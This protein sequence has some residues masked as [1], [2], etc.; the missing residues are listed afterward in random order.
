LL[1]KIVLLGREEKQFN[2]VLGALNDYGF[3]FEFINFEDLDKH[4]SQVIDAKL[5]ILDT[6]PFPES[7][8]SQFHTLRQNSQL[9]HIPVLALVKDSP[10]RLRY[11]IVNLGITEYLTVPF[12]RLDLQMRV[13]NIFQHTNGSMRQNNYESDSNQYAVYALQSLKSLYQEMDKSVVNLGKDTFFDE[14]LESLR[15]LSKAHCAML[16]DVAEEDHLVLTNV[17][18]GGLLETGCKLNILN[19]PILH[20]AV[21]LGEPT[22]LNMI[23][24]DNPF[25]MLMRSFFNI[26][27]KSC[28]V[29]PIQIQKS[30]RSILC[31]LKSDEEKLSEFHYLLVQNF[32]HFIVHSYQLKDLHNEV[33]E[34]L[35]NQIW[36]FYFDFLEQVVN[37]LSFGILV[38]GK[39]QRINYLNEHAAQLLSVLPKETLYRP[40]DEVLDK[41]VIE[42]IMKSKRNITLT[43][44]RP[45]FELEDKSGKKTLI[46]YS[47][48][49]FS[50]KINQEEGYIISLKDI[51]YTKEMQEEMRRVDRL[52]SLGVMASGIAHEIRNPLAG[53][54][55]MVQTF[56]EEL[57]EDDAKRE[58]MRRIVRLVNRLDKLIRTLFSYAKPSKPNR[59]TCNIESILGDV[60]SLLRQKIKE[61]NIKLSELV[62]PDLPDVFVDPSQIQQVLVNLILNSVEAIERDG[63]I[64]ISIQP[65]NSEETTE[66]AN[67]PPSLALGKSRE[68]IEIKI[69]DNG[70]GISTENIQHIFNPFFT[71]KSFGTGLGLS[72]V[73]QIIKDNDGLINYESREGN[74]TTC[75]LYLPSEIEN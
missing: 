60:I 58:Y 32:A 37:Q 72:I 17:R 70:C 16:F 3:Q 31:L 10:P 6:I 12:D 13:R 62:H 8:F 69:Q 52:A 25:V 47:V 55:A 21:R 33:K 51:T 7:L 14:V 9:S 4:T 27:V 71:T 42:D 34:H 20:K 46:G 65:V 19:T 41:Q 24:A 30:T 64:I 67:R 28:I 44:D 59:Q 5:I 26:R 40:L 48:Q 2:F 53:I 1:P 56:E 50:D 18:P 63:Q 73:F 45:E 66:V 39:D 15:K 29:F 49:E 74:G 54:K 68:Y 57:P 36:Q 11:R 22:F 43:A 35:D 38:I 61:K 23:S 75:Y